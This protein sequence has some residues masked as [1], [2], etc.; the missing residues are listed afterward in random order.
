MRTNLNILLLFSFVLLCSCQIA[1]LKISKNSSEPI[2]GER[3]IYSEGMIRTVATVWSKERIHT[4]LSTDDEVVEW[5]DDLGNTWIE[6]IDFTLPVSEWRRADGDIGKHTIKSK[7]GSVFPM[8]VGLE[9]TYKYEGTNNKAKLPWNRQAICRVLDFSKVEV[10]AGAFD[11]YV[12]SCDSDTRIR[13]TYY[14]PRR[15]RV[16]AI[17][18]SHK[19][20][21]KLNNGWRLKS[22][23]TE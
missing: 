12:V 16:V 15:Q 4:V 11:V 13:T 18:E 9:S 5:Q 23:K 22:L 14:D 8:S 19:H 7:E 20:N 2:V 6:P 21:K 17:Q 10:P 1:P 3:P